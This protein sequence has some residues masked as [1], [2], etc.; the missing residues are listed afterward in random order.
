MS[1]ESA[2]AAAAAAKYDAATDKRRATADRAE[3]E[4]LAR[5]TKDRLAEIDRKAAEVRMNED[6]A[7]AARAAAQVAEQTARDSAAKAIV[8]LLAPSTPSVRRVN[9]GIQW[10]FEGND[11]AL[12]TPH[13]VGPLVQARGETGP[14]R[15]QRFPATSR[16]TAT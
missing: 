9:G 10:H 4:K 7:N 1:A 16:N 2:K 3:S 6:K 11:M 14:S 15:S 13:R 12:A 8:D 5:A